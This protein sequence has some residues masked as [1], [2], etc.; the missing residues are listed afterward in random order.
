MLL[1]QPWFWTQSSY[2]Y[3]ISDPDI[4]SPLRSL[5]ILLK[6]LVMVIYRIINVGEYFFNVFYLLC[7]K[8]ENVSFDI[9]ETCCASVIK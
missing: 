5:Q 4:L 2:V 7:L 1:I 8:I 6:Y 3:I 9:S